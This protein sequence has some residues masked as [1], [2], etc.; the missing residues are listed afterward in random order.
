MSENETVAIFIQHPLMQ[1]ILSN[2]DVPLVCISNVLT[3]KLTNY[4]HIVA[5]YSWIDVYNTYEL[6]TYCS[7]VFLE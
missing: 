3:L 4:V 7:P 5:Q 2:H 6:C 1:E